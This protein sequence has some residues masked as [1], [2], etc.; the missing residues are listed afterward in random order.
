MKKV[1]EQ[2]QN[3]LPDL[4]EDENQVVKLVTALHGNEPLPV[5]AMASL[6]LEQVVANPVALAHNQ[7]FMELDMNAAF[8]P[9]G[10]TLEERRAVEVL[11]QIKPNQ[12]V[13]DLHTMSADSPP[14]AI[15]VDLQMVSLARL[16]GLDK[17]V[18]MG[19]NIKAGRALIN[20][21]RGVSVE[22]GQHDDAR[23]FEQ[24]L[25]LTVSLKSGE[26]RKVEI[27]EVYDKITE[28]G[29]YHNFELHPEG[30]YPVLAGEKAY[31]FPGLKAR[32]ID[33]A[34]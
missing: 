26:P 2:L 5:L 9:G 22:V 25:Q 4:P 12:L 10:Q 17:V 31:N 8:G 28:P 18:Y 1:K 30:F 15:V 27:F 11:K 29:E 34:E 24:V 23:S 21:R 14:F 20:Y 16:L 7:R 19:H 3:H 33:P 6:G 13:V 32:K